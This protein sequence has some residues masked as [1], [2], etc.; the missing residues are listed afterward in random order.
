MSRIFESCIQPIEYLFVRILT[1]YVSLLKNWNSFPCF[2]IKFS[3]HSFVRFLFPDFWI[4]LWVENATVSGKLVNLDSV[5]LRLWENLVTSFDKLFSI[6]SVSRV[7]WDIGKKEGQL[8]LTD[9]CHSEYGTDHVCMFCAG[10][11][12]SFLV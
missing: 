7:K 8:K 9:Q 12:L 2:K 6:R 11:W 4:V 3:L 1:N 5:V 10:L